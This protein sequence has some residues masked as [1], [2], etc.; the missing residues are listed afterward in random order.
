MKTKWDT[1]I[2]DVTTL[3]RD[4]M[5][6]VTKEKAYDALVDSV[7]RVQMMP[8]PG[9]QY[10]VGGPLICMLD[11]LE[12]PVQIGP[13]SCQSVYVNMP[14]RKPSPYCGEVRAAVRDAIQELS[15]DPIGARVLMEGVHKA[16][17]PLPGVYTHETNGYRVDLKRWS[18]DR[19]SY[20]YALVY[21][22]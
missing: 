20:L 7:L 16:G 21:E 18:S 12:N 22:R 13:W 19:Q 5:R 17:H 15:E 14:Y 10:M 4:V 11:E 2:D 3:Q 9:S 1:L 8:L 6:L